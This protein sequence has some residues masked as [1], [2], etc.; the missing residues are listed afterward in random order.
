MSTSWR[1][2]GKVLVSCNCDWGCP[3]NFN[4]RPT[5][6]HCEGGWTWH[7]ETGEFGGVTLDGLSLSVYAKWPGAIH[8][9]NGEALLLVDERAD[10]GQ[11]SA[12][13]ALLAGSSG[14][15]W[16][17][18]AWTWPNIHGPF[19]VAYELHFDGVRSRAR[20]GDL[21]EIVGGAI[22]NPVT[23]AE[24]FPAVTLPQGIV[25]KQAELGATTSFRVSGGV[26]YDH[27]GQYLAV[28]PFRYSSA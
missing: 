5:A 24:A 25:F 15:P 20:C 14:G 11:Q 18:S 13:E 21:V 19:K 4:A 26:E 23:G 8:E 17:T 2:A 6:G 7:I 9:G 27:S 1:L 10:A 16:G 12:L 3:C 28:A 22:R